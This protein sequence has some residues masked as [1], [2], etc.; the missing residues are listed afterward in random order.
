MSG[1]AAADDLLPLSVSWRDWL[2][3]TAWSG[4]QLSGAPFD[5][6]VIGSGYGG[7]VAALRLAGKGY[8]TLVLERGSEYLPGEFPNDFGL[9]PKSLRVNVPTEGLPVGRASGLIEFHVGQGMVAITGNGLGGGSLIN[10]GVAI[11]PDADVFAQPA[12]PAAIR[13]GLDGGLRP[14]FDKATRMLKARQ[15]NSALPQAKGQLRKTEALERLAHTLDARATSLRL[16]IDGSRCTR[17]GDCASGCNVPDAKQTLRLTYLRQA[18]ESGLV[19]IVTQAEVYRFAPS[20]DA[21]GAFAW[22]LEAFATDAQHQFMA[23]RELFAETQA[24]ATHRQLQA[25]L[26]FVCAG[27]LGSTQLL[28]RSQAR[29]GGRLS[30]S[31]RLGERLSGNGDSLGWLTDEP[32]PVGSVGRGEAGLQAWDKA[33]ATPEQPYAPETIC[34]PTITK[35]IDLRKPTL[36]LEERLLVQDGAVPRAIALLAREL[37]ASART[38]QHLDRW[39]FGKLRHP[40]AGEEDPLA[41]SA[42]MAQQSQVLLT[43][44]HDGSPGRLVWLDGS[45]RTAPYLLEP[46]KLP[47]YQAQQRLFDKL[48]ARH[49]HLPLWRPLPR[50]ATD[51]MDGPTPGATVTTVHPLGG[52]VMADRPQDGVVD[53]LGRVWVHDPSAPEILCAAIE[54]DA[55]GDDVRS[56]AHRYRGLFV[57]DGSIVPTALGCNPLLTITALAERALEHFPG[58]PQASAAAPAMR[59]PRRQPEASPSTDLPFAAT[60]RE[61]LLTASFELR[62][63]LRRAF[64]AREVPARLAASFSTPDLPSMLTRA[65]HELPVQAKLWLGGPGAAA[66]YEAT[67]GWLQLAPASRSSSGSWPLVSIVLQLLALAAAFCIAAM[68]VLDGAWVAAC[69][70]AELFLLLVLALPAPRF[71][72]TWWTLRGRQDA[73]DTA[74]RRTGWPLVRWWLSLAQSMLKQMVHGSEKRVMRYHVELQRKEPGG[75]TGW[76]ERLILLARKRVTYRA[77]IAQHLRHDWA[78]LRGHAI[79]LRETFWEQVMDAQVRLVGT[80]LLAGWRSWGRGRMRMGFDSLA[81]IGKP[82][83]P[84][85]GPIALGPI[86]DTTNGLLAAAGYPLLFLRLAIKSRMFDFRLPAYSGLPVPDTVANA[87]VLRLANGRRCRAEREWVEDVPRGSC[88]SDSGDEPNAPLRLPVWRYRQRDA[89]GAPVHCDVQRGTWQGVP[90]ARA[91]A[92][93]LLH[94]FGQSGL[95]FTLQS[96]ERNLAE[97]FLAA[98]YE[99][100]VLEMRMSTRSGYGAEPCTVDQIGRHDIPA[101]VRHILGRLAEEQPAL[102]GEKRHWQMAAYAHCVGSAALWMALLS[103]KLTHGARAPGTGDRGPLLSMLSHCMSSQLHPWVVGGRAAQPKTWVPALLSKVWRRASVPFAVRGSQQGLLPALLD[104]VFASLPVPLEENRRPAGATHDD[105]AATC[106]RIRFIDA[107]LFDHA[108]IGDGTLA[109]MN[110]LFGDANLR[111][112]GQAR[113]FI[114]RG[115][116]VDEDGINSYVTDANIARHLAFPIQLVHGSRNA[117]FDLSGAERSFARLGQHHGG[118]QRAFCMGPAGEPAFIRSEGY[119][120]L[121]GLI[122]DRAHAEVHPAIVA[123]FERAHATVDHGPP[124]ASRAGWTL[125]APGVGPFIGWVRERPDGTVHVRVSFMP[126]DGGLGAKPVV[127]LRRWDAQQGR[128]VRWTGAARWRT[129]DQP[130]ARMVWGDIALAAAPAADDRWQLLVFTRTRTPESEVQHGPRTNDEALDRVIAERDAADALECAVPP[131]VRSGHRMHRCEFRLPAATFRSLPAGSDVTFAAGTCRHPGLGLDQGRIDGMVQRFLKGPRSKQVAFAALLGD[132]IYADAT[133][134]LVDPLSPVERFHERHEMAFARGRLGDLL[135]SLPVYMTPDDHE[136][137]DNYPLGAPLASRPWPRWT[138][139]GLPFGPEEREPFRMAAGAVTAFQRLQSPSGNGPADHYDFRHG[140]TRVFALDTRLHRRRNQPSV[141]QDLGPLEAWL[142]EPEARQMPE[143]RDVRL[144]R[145]AG[146]A[147]GQRPGRARGDGHVA[148]G[149]GPAPGTVAPAGAACAGALPAA[150]GRLPR[151]RRRA[152][153]GGRRHGGRGRGG[154]ALV[155]AAALCQQRARVGVRGRGRGPGRAGHAA[156]AGAAARRVRGGIGIGLR[157]GAAPRRR[158]RHHVPAHIVGV[159]ARPP[160][161]AALRPEP[162]GGRPGRRLTLSRARRGRSR[163]LP[164][165]GCR[166]RRAPARTPPRC[167]WTPPGRRRCATR[168]SSRWHRTGPGR[169][170]SPCSACPA[171]CPAAPGA[172]DR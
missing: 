58:K 171:R 53:H 76:P 1:A 129:Q 9:V 145:P 24:A 88:R 149:T 64:G 57:L 44:G 150:L 140:C 82:G 96:T 6:I 38:L 32:V 2:A 87:E 98:G 16:T 54:T 78:R 33:T 85:A 90:V 138:H 163:R 165:R 110:Q 39:W 21:A 31:P 41:A 75:Q 93:L 40:G 169:A 153:D 164:A 101:T 12:W 122:G 73:Q 7:S 112:F 143:R 114:E 160:D 141:V 29:S 34:G 108:N 11:E 151:E 135:A 157:D 95:S 137:G 35:A 123:F 106:R 37:L 97:S 77:T 119:G 42:A 52:C 83:Q 168:A 28:Q 48:G 55:I 102:A 103:G 152:A 72:L 27:T 68:A 36:G 120:H 117:L 74:S 166:R 139:G 13:H 127:V 61:E 59:H 26:L 23:T 159:G 47:T 81:G 170:R 115:R 25:P 116:L 109:I 80:G 79:P 125:R 46:D 136:W 124:A 148:A 17:C 132:Q 156:D 62:G 94:A 172:G 86:G 63:P 3:S 65:R 92:V 126:E 113:R 4:R 133:A 56:R 147:A 50:T 111:L 155:C 144:G 121:D 128:F 45:D 71:L 89:Q 105:A 18:M 84:V 8:R 67:C 43:M 118:W 154:A 158:L 10:A 131:L 69:L 162:A 91:K 14:H 100:W 99:V 104:R 134:G 20:T 107:P 70:R 49:V 142:L 66:L 161:G 130:A 167:G 146:P 15:W 51:L 22:E 5:A 30:F 19:Q 60:L